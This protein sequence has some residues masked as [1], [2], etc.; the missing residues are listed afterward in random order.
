MHDVGHPRRDPVRYRPLPPG[1]R[2]DLLAATAEELFTEFGE[3][4]LPFD[5][6]ADAQ[7][8]LIVVRRAQAGQK[9]TAMA[10]DGF[11][12]QIAAIGASRDAPIAT[13]TVADLSG[14]GVEIIDPWNPGDRIS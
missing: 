2:R 14:T 1:R 3:Q 11:D 10:I 8:A 5:A 7:Y 6:A 4:V 13:R 12:A 9:R